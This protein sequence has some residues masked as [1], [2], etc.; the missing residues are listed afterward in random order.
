MNIEVGDMIP[1]DETPDGYPFGAE[2]K[3]V[4]INERT[5]TVFVLVYDSYDPLHESG[6]LLRFSDAWG[7]WD[8]HDRFKVERFGEGM[9]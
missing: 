8:Y 3:V 9:N 1:F 5:G 6:T 4:Y 2:G 7:S